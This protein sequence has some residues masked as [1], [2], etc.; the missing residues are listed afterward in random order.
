MY[1][2]S[3]PGLAFVACLFVIASAE[4]ATHS[5]LAKG[6][7]DVLHPDLLEKVRDECYMFAD[8]GD[9]HNPGSNL[10]HGKK[11]TNFFRLSSEPRNYVELAV[12]Q[13]FDLS[14]PETYYDENY[15]IKHYGE[16]TTYKK[17]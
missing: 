12:H 5:S 14:F 7:D 8:L 10:K 15:Q 6:F 9:I 13:F 4:E 3:F 2:A 1:Y 11:S 16:R 17:R